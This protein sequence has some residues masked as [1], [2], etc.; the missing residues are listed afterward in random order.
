VLTFEGY[1]KHYNEPTSF[2]ENLK[3]AT[4]LNGIERRIGQLDVKKLIGGGVMKVSRDKDK[5]I[6]A[7]STSIT[8]V[9][10]GGL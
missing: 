7:Y 10:D 6:V 3:R 5:S 1:S 8:N 4:I 2:D 9:T